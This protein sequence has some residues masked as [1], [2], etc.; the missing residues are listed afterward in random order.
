MFINHHLITNPFVSAL[1]YPI[2]GLN[3]TFATTMISLL[4]NPSFKNDITPN[5]PLD[6]DNSNK[7]NDLPLGE[8]IRTFESPQ[9]SLILSGCQNTAV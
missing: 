2:L 1:L 5:R 6:D 8:R 9:G 4:S 3:W 7:K